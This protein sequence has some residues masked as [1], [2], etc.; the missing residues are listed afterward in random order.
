MTKKRGPLERPRIL[1]RRLRNAPRTRRKHACPV[2]APSGRHDLSLGPWRPRPW[3]VRGEA[4]AARTGMCHL[5]IN[6][7]EGRLSR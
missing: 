7:V 2:P 4:W 1:Q 5:G 3:Q 6:P